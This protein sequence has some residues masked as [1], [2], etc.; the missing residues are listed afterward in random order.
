MKSVE[1]ALRVISR[2]SL[3]LFILRSSK[4]EVTDEHKTVSTFVSIENGQHA[5]DG[6][7]KTGRSR[8]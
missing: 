8:I 2:N 6:D 4:L 5:V 1:N 3:H 7:A